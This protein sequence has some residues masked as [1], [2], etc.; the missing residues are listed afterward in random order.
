MESIKPILKNISDVKN[1]PYG[2]VLNTFIGLAASVYSF[3]RIKFQLEKNELSKTANIYCMNFAPSGFGKNRTFDIVKNSCFRKCY[4]EIEKLLKKQNEYRW[5]ELKLEADRLF[6]YKEKGSGYTDFNGRKDFIARN[7][8]RAITPI[9]SD[10]TVEGLQADRWE[11]SQCSQG[12]IL[13]KNTEF[14]EYLLAKDKEKSTTLSYLGD[15]YDGDD[16]AKSVKS[17]NQSKKFS[18]NIPQNLLVYASVNFMH[19]DSS[20]NILMANL[21]K[22]FARRSFL[23][24]DK[25]L[26]TEVLSFEARKALLKKSDLDNLDFNDFFVKAFNEL[27]HRHGKD[28]IIYELEFDSIASDLFLQF[29]TENEIQAQKFNDDVVKTELIGRHWKTMKLATI[30]HAIYKPTEKYICEQA[31][32]EAIEIAN[33]F[34]DC[35]FEFTSNKPK[36]DFELVYEYFERNI[37]KPISAMKLRE[38]RFFNNAYFKKY[39]EE[40]KEYLREMADSKG[41]IFE[42]MKGAGNTKLY[43]LKKIEEKLQGE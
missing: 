9:L 8:P 1:I 5:S 26:K 33:Y 30:L 40:L 32:V 3:H 17:H 37:G 35:F 15:I 12:S 36:L 43:V 39:F 38:K 20:F 29:Q 11:L 2:I 16:V 25:D 10:I 41:C 21:S 7:E 19:K 42:E 27:S 28:N 22:S 23:F 4:E 24:Y 6:P 14:L 34:G 13:F 31:M 18:H